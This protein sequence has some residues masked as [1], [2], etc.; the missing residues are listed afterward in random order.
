ML[1]RFFK[2]LARRVHHTICC[3]AGGDKLFELL[4]CLC[5]DLG[6]LHHLLNISIRQATRCGD[7]DRLLLAGR[8]IFRRHVQ[9][10]VGVEI[11]GHLDL[12]HASRRGRN[13]G[14]VKA[15]Q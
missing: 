13:I 9:D 5:I 10:A 4:I 15:P 3:V 1:T 2:R 11:K 8:L 14:Q 7:P 6:I 12:R